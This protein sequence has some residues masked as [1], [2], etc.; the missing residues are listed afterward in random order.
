MNKIKIMLVKLASIISP[1]WGLKLQTRI[2]LN[3]YFKKTKHQIVLPNE[4][5]N[6][7]PQHIFPNQIKHQVFSTAPSSSILKKRQEDPCCRSSGD[8]ELRCSRCSLQGGPPKIPDLFGTEQW[9]CYK[10]PS[11][12]KWPKIQGF[13]KAISGG[14][15][16]HAGE[17][18]KRWSDGGGPNLYLGFWVHFIG[19]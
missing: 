9:L 14:A 12:Q 15:F 3:L 6:T 16:L 11:L 10:N 1:I 13:N 18:K 8:P 5:E 19:T 2:Y 7:H 4:Q 17:K